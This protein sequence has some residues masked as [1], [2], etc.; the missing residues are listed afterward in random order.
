MF[1]LCLIFAFTFFSCSTTKTLQKY[2]FDTFQDIA[3]NL[4]AFSNSHLEKDGPFKIELKENFKVQQGRNPIVAD[5]YLPDLQG[6]A[7]VA[8]FQHG[9]HS[10][11][12][13]H[14][15]QARRLATWGFIALTVQQ[16]NS[17]N[18]I[19]NGK[20]LS[21]FVKNLYVA[22]NI[23]KHPINNNNIVLIGHSFGGSAV[24]I[25]ASNGAPVSGLI[26]LDP[27]VV[28]DSVLDDMS[29][30]HQP[31]MLLGADKNIF[32]SK[33]R[34]Q[35]FNRISG[36]MGEISVWKAT[37]DDAQYPSMF[38]IHAFGIDPY[39]DS[40]KQDTFLKA[41]TTTALSLA[42][43]KNLKFA[44]SHF[45]YDIRRGELRYPRKRAALLGE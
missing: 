2:N 45:K 13:A 28:A 38:S 31:V 33:R 36:S 34:F 7:P 18:W 8:I 41:I 1:R 40:K 4:G 32:K 25:A 35:F 42:V 29:K 16:K 6:P 11:K 20:N 37:H 3:N 24:T 39:T 9:N 30:V 19:N 22:K 5:V 23:A 21:R 10:Y 14:R 44:W 15:F 27:A 17:N 26:L 43:N 12:E